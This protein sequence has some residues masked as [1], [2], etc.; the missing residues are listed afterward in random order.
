MNKKVKP[1]NQS[2]VKGNEPRKPR[3]LTANQKY[4]PNLMEDRKRLKNEMTGAEK[5]LWEELRNKK[6]GV[7]F[8]RQHVI[9]CFIPDFV[10]LPLKLIIEV[11]GGIHLKQKAKDNMREERL[12]LLGYSILRFK[13]EE[14]INDIKLVCEKI[15]NSIMKLGKC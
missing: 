12:R 5:V 15:K 8:R 9:D 11:D 2:T 3:W 4:Y 1:Q 6:L 14:V 10:C 7:K 13:N